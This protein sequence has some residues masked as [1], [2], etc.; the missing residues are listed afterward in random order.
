MPPS[1]ENY[2]QEAGR[3]GRDGEPAKCTLLFQNKDIITQ[4]WL[5][6]QNYPSNKQVMDVLQYLQRQGDVALKAADIAAACA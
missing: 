6:D 3:A 5:V 1:L 4:R 2:Y